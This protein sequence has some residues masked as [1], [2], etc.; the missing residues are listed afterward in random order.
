MRQWVIAIGVVLV[1]VG[2]LWPWISRLGLGSLP[3]DVMVERAS[4]SRS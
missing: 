1:V 4:I 2:L 3:G